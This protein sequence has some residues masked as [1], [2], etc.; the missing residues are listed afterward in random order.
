MK[1]SSGSA[2]PLNQEEGI[3]YA[4]LDP[5]WPDGAKW[6]LDVAGHYARP[7]VFQL[8]VHREARPIMSESA[9]FDELRI[10]CAALRL[11]QC[12]WR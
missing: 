11:V 8:T 9:S 4:E 6:S 7:D 10:T 2:G 1:T 5:Q 3:L 12:R